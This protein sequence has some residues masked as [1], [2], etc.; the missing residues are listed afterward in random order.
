[1]FILLRTNLIKFRKDINGLRSIAVIAVV[2]F[3]FNTN[4]VPGCFA[5]VDIFFVISG[6]LMTA[7]IFKKIEQKTFL[8]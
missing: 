1:M 3:H 5:G 7:I 2:L 6:F 8:F 4:L